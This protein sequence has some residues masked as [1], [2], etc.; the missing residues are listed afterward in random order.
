MNTEATQNSGDC[1]DRMETSDALRA[2]ANHQVRCIEAVAQVSEQI[3]QAADLMVA[4]IRRGGRLIYAGAGSSGLMAIADGLEVP[5]TYG[6]PAER[7]SLL[8]A[9]GLPANSRMPGDTE[10]D[11]E[12]GNRAADVIT[13]ADA[14]IILTASGNTPYAMAVARH[15]VE[16]GANVICLANNADAQI[17]EFATI[18]IL[19]ETPPELVAGSTRMGAGTAQ[20]ATLNMMSTLMGLKLGHVHDGMMVNLIVDNSKLRERA[21]RMVQQIAN[22]SAQNA[23]VALEQTEFQVKP[24]VLI[25]LGAPTASEANKTL[26]ACEGNLR[27]AIARIKQPDND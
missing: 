26:A 3:A 18:A 20:K 11:S 16:V 25:V 2:I 17:F 4:A 21:T 23:V 27:A 24:A 13:N 6:I 9:G 22:V 10:D 1:I 7:I 14:V 12:A 15:A 8:M 5:G 19:L